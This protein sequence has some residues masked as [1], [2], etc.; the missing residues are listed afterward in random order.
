[1]KEFA[2]Q[3]I[4]KGTETSKLDIDTLSEQL[5]NLQHKV[6]N[7]YSLDD[8]LKGE[9]GKA[10]RSFYNEIHTPFLTF[11]LQS[12]EDYKNRLENMKNDVQS[13]EPNHQGYISEGF[14]DDELHPGLDKAKSKVASVS[15]NINSVLSGVADIKFVAQISYSDFE[16]YIEKGKRKIDEVITDLGELDNKHT[17]HLQETQ[18]DLETMKK[19]LSEMTTGLNSGAISISDFDAASLQDMNAYNNVIQQSYGNGNI[20]ITEDNIE[21]LP[22]AAIAAAKDH[23]S[24]GMHESFRVLLDHALTDLQ[25]GNI[26]REEYYDIYTLASKTKV[27][28]KEE[29][30]EE[31]VPDSVLDYINENK[32]KM[33][34]D[35]SNDFLAN[36]LQQ[37][38]RTTTKLGGFITVM[39]G[40]RG[41]DIPNT[42]VMVNPNTAGFTNSLKNTG[43]AIL[44]GGKWLGRGVMGVG[45]GVGMYE[46]MNQ[47]DKSFGEALVHNSA[48][49]GIG[50]AGAFLGTA[51]TAFLLGSNPAGWAVLGGVAVSAV[52]V[53]GFNYFYDNNILGLQDG[54]DYVGGKIDQ[55]WESTKD[56]AGDAIDSIAETTKDIGEA[57][58]SG[59]DAI[60]PMNWG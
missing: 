60:N 52:F 20:E 38:G 16:T 5:S 28:L 33:Q 17:S 34:K 51:A 13:F 45:F 2:V 9:T 23:K 14:L 26:T 49:L 8:A 21:H 15:E 22:M 55:A 4:H 12:M 3:E 10:I 39:T 24:D 44:N 6:R 47:K 1:M 7:L 56:A 41:P 50:S 42:F 59:F 19:Y 18:S 40:T 30:L 35:F 29:E 31:D 11:L 36:V 54:L 32:E 27:T 25:Q 58:S 53:G 57:I 46:D 43:Q 37:V 48:S